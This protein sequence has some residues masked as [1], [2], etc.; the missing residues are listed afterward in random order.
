MRLVRNYGERRE[1][2]KKLVWKLAVFKAFGVKGGARCSRKGAIPFADIQ[3]GKKRR[4]TGGIDFLGRHIPL[5]NVGLRKWHMKGIS[6]CSVYT[7]CACGM[8]W[9]G[10]SRLYFKHCTLIFDPWRIGRSLTF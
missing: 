9:P 10:I 5:C 4:D 1:K 8:E 6:C 2:R 3:E 7:N